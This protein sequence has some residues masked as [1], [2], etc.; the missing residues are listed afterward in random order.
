[1]FRKIVGGVI[2]PSSL[3]I[4]PTFYYSEISEYITKKYTKNEKKF[5]GYSEE[6]NV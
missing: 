3:I 6:A 2:L 5:E 1:M 4:I